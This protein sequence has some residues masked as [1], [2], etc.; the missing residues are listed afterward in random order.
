MAS[1]E[2][3]LLSEIERDLLD[4]KPLA[5]LLRKC[6]MLGGKAGSAELRDWASKEL[7]GYEPG[8]DPPKY[9]T[10]GA[11]LMADAVTGNSIIRGQRISPSI[12]PEFAREDIQEELTLRHGVGELEALVEGRKSDDAIRISIPMAADIGGWIDRES[13]NPWQHINAI[14][15]SIV[16]ASIHRILDNVRTSM[17]EIVAELAGTMPRGQEVPTADQA[18]QAVQV[19]VH[20]KRSQVHVTTAQATGD[21]S[22]S[23]VSGAAQEADPDPAWWTLGRKIGAFVVGCAVIIGAVVAVLAY[24]H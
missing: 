7:R 9:R 19:A 1:R 8:D 11:P 22:T 2:Q 15:W 10:V 16:P 23:T 6:V 21:G 18:H 20:G 13:G 4:G 17:T 24:Y 14:Y 12:L 3:N 5:D